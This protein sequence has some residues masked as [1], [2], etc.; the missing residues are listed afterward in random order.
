MAAEKWRRRAI[1][2]TSVTLRSSVG[3]ASLASTLG[4]ANISRGGTISS[5]VPAGTL[6]LTMGVTTGGTN[7][8]G[9]ANAGT[10]GLLDLSKNRLR[11][12]HAGRAIG[13]DTI[14]FGTLTANHNGSAG[15]VVLG[16]SAGSGE[17]G[18]NVNG[19]F[20]ILQWPTAGGTVVCVPYAA[21][22]A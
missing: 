6:A 3:A 13:G 21:G 16:H 20:F 17:I 2:A 12:P 8:A 15:D 7:F 22:V 9:T 5:G 19:T 11:L 1:F 4:F 14:G 10:I 18:L